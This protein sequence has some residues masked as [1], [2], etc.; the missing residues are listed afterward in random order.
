MNHI[1][2][3]CALNELRLSRLNI[4]RDLNNVN[5]FRNE[6]HCSIS[7]NGVRVLRKSDWIDEIRLNFF[8]QFTEATIKSYNLC[9]L[10]FEV[11]VNFNDGPQ[12][13]SKE[14]RFCFARPRNSP[15]ICIPDSHLLRTASICSQIGNV[16]IPFEEKIDKAVFC[17]SDTGA[18]H[19]GSVQRIDLCRKYRYSQL[20][21]AKI[22]NFVEFPF[23][24]DIAGPYTTIADQLKYKY[25]LNINGNTTSWERLIWAMKSN[26]ICIYV[27][28]PSHQDEISWYYHMFDVVQGVVYVDQDCIEH[29]MAQMGNDKNYIQSIK[30]C[31]K[32]LANTLDKPDVHAAYFSSILKAYNSYYNGGADV[33]ELS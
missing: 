17:G 22:T 25:I 13:D 10:D 3:Y 11:I 26:S 5:L 32:Y 1:L 21:D 16:D 2:A 19:N 8:I 14:T 9:D 6:A 7:A 27:R 31:Q 20:V 33:Q 28:P 15:H 23:E 4:S 12:N 24:D 30:N 18:K 29:F